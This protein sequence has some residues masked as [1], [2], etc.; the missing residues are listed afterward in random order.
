MINLTIDGK[1]VSVVEGSSILDA[2]RKIDIDIPTLCFLKEINEVGNCRMCLV[3][4]DGVKGYKTSCVYPAEEGMNVKTNTKDLIETKRE[5]LQLILSAHDKKCLSCV[6]NTNCT[7]QDLCKK[8]EIEDYDYDGEMPEAI[9]D[10]A[11]ECIVRNTAK[12]ILC[13]RCVSVC[14]NVQG[15]SAISVM[16]RGYKSR[17]GVALGMSIKKSTCVGCGQ[18]IIHCPV[19]ALTEKSNVKQL[20][21][22][23]VDPKKHVVIQTAPSVRASIGEEFG[24]P[25]GSLVTGKMVTSLRKMG[26]DK[27][28]DTDLGADITIMEEATEFI[29]RLKNGGTL[30]MITSCS[31]GWITFAEKFYPDQLKD[32][33]TVKSPMEILGT[34]IKTYYADKMNIDPKDIY[35]VAL[36]PCSAKKAEIIREELKLDNGLQAVDNVVTTREMARLLKESNIDL[37]MCEDSE[38]DAPLGIATGAGH[39]FGAT[40]G[41]MEAALRSVSY[42][43]DGTEIGKVEFKSV[44]GNNN[45]K[46]ADIEIAGKIHKIAVVQGLLSVSKVLDE[47]KNGTSK[48]SFIEAM[49]C[50]GGCVNGGGQPLVDEYKASKIDYKALRTKALYNADKEAEFKKSHENPSVKEL[51]K[52]FLGEP[53]GKKSHELL[54][55]KYNKQDTYVD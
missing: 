5:I 2:A 13:G 16:N 4:I 48:Y 28:F 22:A 9:L 47:I 3:E 41:V 40:G 24:M 10:D 43:L 42:L 32:L 30:P 44:I 37:A 31:S 52:N 26:F 12:C 20:K 46:E 39:I 54:H 6:R 51:Y 27:I 33:S 55:T 7:L 1:N 11:S 34:L 18:C 14:K 17:V 45:I 23:L 29:S 35:S 21:E 19:G 49:T 53:N 8:F 38:F 25:I 50:P 15:V 36:M